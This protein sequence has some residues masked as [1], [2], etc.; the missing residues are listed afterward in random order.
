L[1]NLLP[2]SRAGGTGKFFVY[3]NRFFPGS[4]RVAAI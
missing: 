3:D 2:P 1:I 4:Q